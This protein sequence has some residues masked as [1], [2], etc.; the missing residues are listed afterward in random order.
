MEEKS[1]AKKDKMERK[2]METLEVVEKHEDW[3]RNSI[4]G[5]IRD[6]NKKNAQTIR[7]KENDTFGDDVF[8]DRTLENKDQEIKRKK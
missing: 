6:A 1:R 4:F 2:F 8:L 3:L 5:E 7:E